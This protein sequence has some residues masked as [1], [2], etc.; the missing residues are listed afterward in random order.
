[1]EVTLDGNAAPWQVM[2]KRN[3]RVWV[4]MEG[5]LLSLNTLLNFA[6]NR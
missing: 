3:A 5:E 4:K 1:M 6:S 2:L